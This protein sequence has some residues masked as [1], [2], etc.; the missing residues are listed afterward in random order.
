[1][2]HECKACRGKHPQHAGGKEVDSLGFWKKRAAKEEKKGSSGKGLLEE[3]G[4]K[5]EENELPHSPKTIDT[6]R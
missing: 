5:D 6:R 3:G 4:K 2:G 1:M